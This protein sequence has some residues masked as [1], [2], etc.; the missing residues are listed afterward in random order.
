MLF[1]SAAG[2]VALL[3]TITVLLARYPEGPIFQPR[4]SEGAV[5]YLEGVAFEGTVCYV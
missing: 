5:D 3:P 1:V 4:A 2:V